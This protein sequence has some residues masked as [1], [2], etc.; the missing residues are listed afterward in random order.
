M[1]WLVTGA[2]G[3]LGL[4]LVEV[5]RGQDVRAI[6]RADCDLRDEAAVRS[7]V[8][9]WVY[10]G[11]GDAVIVNAAAYTAVDAAEA[12]EDTAAVVNGL[13]PGWIAAAAGPRARVIQVSTDYVFAGNATAPYEVEDPTG[14]RTAYGR[15]KLAGERAVLV[16]AAHPWVVRTAWVYGAHGSNFVRTMLRLEAER[17]TVS[18]VED[19][20]GSPTWSA[21]L[22]RALVELGGSATP[23][24]VYHCTGAGQTSWL[25]LAQSV[26]A[27]AGAD[28]GRVLAASSAEVPRPAPRPAYSGLSNASWA[29]AGLAPLPHWRDAVEDAVPRILAGK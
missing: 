16:T 9:S 14:P 20:H 5:L 15:T 2:H 21:Q 13:A 7:V 4:D 29:A 6:G 1:R 12:D 24:G 3:Q 18:V 23:P 22:A 28:P 10:A 27:A 19:Q 25:G 17:E 8:G 11:D 26:F